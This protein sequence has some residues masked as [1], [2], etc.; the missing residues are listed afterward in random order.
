VAGFINYCG[1]AGRQGGLATWIICNQLRIRGNR[2]SASTLP[3]RCACTRVQF[4]C[5]SQM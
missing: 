5:L 1:A 3:A 2:G 4:G